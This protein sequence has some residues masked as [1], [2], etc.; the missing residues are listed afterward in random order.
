MAPV[1]SVT[2]ARGPRAVAVGFLLVGSIILVSQVWDSLSW[3]ARGLILAAYG[4]T[5]LAVGLIPGL[6][7]RA[8]LKRGARAEGVVVGTKQVTRQGEDGTSYSYHP[9][10]RFTAPDGGQVVFTSSL[11]SPVAP[12]L[13]TPVPVRYRPEDPHQAEVDRAAAWVLPAAFGLVGGLGLLVAAVVVYAQESGGAPAV[14]GTVTGTEAAP[15]LEPVPEVR[16][17][18]PKVATGKVGDKLTAYDQSGT[19]QLEVTVARVKLSTGDQVDQPEHGF[20]LGAYVTARAVG[21]DQEVLD[22]VAL[23]G[24][25]IYEETITVSAAFDPT[26]DVLPFNQGER[27]SGWLV[28]DVPARHGKLVMRDLDEHQVGVWTY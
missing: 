16:S 21:D 23:V 15:A 13:G 2:F 19:A 14:V 6:R 7:T 3:H 24:G 18:T 26:L 5:A 20:F 12:D 9:V 4:V 8:L 10:V 1:P 22:L 25:R 27:A 17:P 11:G 28:F